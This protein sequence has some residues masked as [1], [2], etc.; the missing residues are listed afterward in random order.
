MSEKTIWQVGHTRLLGDGSL[1]MG[2]APELW[3]TPLPDAEPIPARFPEPTPAA[4]NHL[5][6][7]LAAL[8]EGLDASSR[9][10]NHYELVNPHD[11]ESYWWLDVGEMLYHAYTHNSHTYANTLDR[12]QTILDLAV[13]AKAAE[14]WLRQLAGAY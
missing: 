8:P 5:L 6:D 13:A 4:I 14:P 3:D 9:E 11:G 7:L 2:R 1:L 12:L 10:T